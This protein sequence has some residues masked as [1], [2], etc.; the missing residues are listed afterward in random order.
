MSVTC[1]EC[2]QEKPESAFYARSDRPG[3]FLSGC[4]DCRS[5]WARLRR[6]EAVAR[7]RALKPADVLKRYHFNPDSGVFT[8]KPVGAP[9]TRDNGHGYLVLTLEGLS[10]LAHRVAWLMY[11]GEWP[12]VEVDHQDH[13]RQNNTRAN[14]TLAP[15][16]AN[17]RNT[18][19]SRRNTSGVVGVSWYEARKRWIAQIGVKQPGRSHNKV[20]GLFTSMEEAI[21][22]RRQ[23]EAAL[24]Y[25]PNHGQRKG[26]QGSEAHV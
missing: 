14:L 5:G 12:S 8:T 23:A 10:V 1:H 4:K 7:V 3:A 21:A 11:H 22:A 20:L 9:V 2:G 19:L 6:K 17:A 18:S 13:N 25:H 26:A 15:H 16:G 24:G